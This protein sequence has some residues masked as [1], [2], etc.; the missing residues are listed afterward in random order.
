[1]ISFSL[2][3]LPP[4]LTY[5]LIGYGRD[6]TQCPELKSEVNY[7]TTYLKISPLDSASLIN[8]IREP[9]TTFVIV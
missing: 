4:Y 8:H 7:F 1:M 5:I 3:V 2:S 6:G 9:I